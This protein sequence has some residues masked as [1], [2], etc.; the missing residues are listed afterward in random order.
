MGFC[1][2]SPQQ[3]VKYKLWYLIFFFGGDLYKYP[4]KNILST[5][6]FLPTW[7][8]NQRY[9]PGL[10]PTEVPV[11]GFCTSSPQYV[12]KYQL[13]YLNFFCGGGLYE[14]PMTNILRTQSSY[15][16]GVSIQSFRGAFNW[17]K[18]LRRFLHLKPTVVCQISTLIYEFSFVE[19]NRYK[20]LNKNILWTTKFLPTWGFNQRYWP[21]LYL[22]EVPGCVSA[23]QAHSRLSNINFDI[24]F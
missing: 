3:G 8:L 13:W 24:W 15:P 22:T 23:P 16:L 9:C 6:K 20:Y 11:W 5:A 1:T 21:G 18:C 17:L 19:R 2:S 14:Y 12:V 10:E 4:M 7:R